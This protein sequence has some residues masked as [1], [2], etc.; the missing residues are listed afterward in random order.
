MVVLP[1][2]EPFAVANGLA[3][4]SDT[5]GSN[6]RKFG[7]FR[8]RRESSARPTLANPFATANGSD[9]NTTQIRARSDTSPTCATIRFHANNCSTRTHARFIA[10]GADASARPSLSAVDHSPRDG[11]SGQR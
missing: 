1:L 9:N 7:L 6:Q 5:D 10:F 11:D 3:G 2:S 8:V 4:P